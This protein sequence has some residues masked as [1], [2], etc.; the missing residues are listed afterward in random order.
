ME[1]KH[2]PPKFC[3]ICHLY[4]KRNGT[5]RNV[6]GKLFEDD[7][8]IVKRWVELERGNKRVSSSDEICAA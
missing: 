7:E 2:R 5:H 1:G 3:A 8:K 4:F 6:V